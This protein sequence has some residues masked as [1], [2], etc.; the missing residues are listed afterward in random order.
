MSKFFCQTCHALGKSLKGPGMA[1]EW[2]CLQKTQGLNEPDAHSSGYAR[3]LTGLVWSERCETKAVLV[4]ALWARLEKGEG[5]MSQ[6]NKVVAL[7]GV[8]GCIFRQVLGIDNAFRKKA[9]ACTLVEKPLL[10]LLTAF[11]NVLE[12]VLFKARVELEG[13]WLQCHVAA[14]FTQLSELCPWHP[15]LTHQLQE[16]PALILVT[17]GLHSCW[18]CGVLFKI[19][20]LLGSKNK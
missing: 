19:Q 7:G 13:A 10:L 6:R 2:N 4:A 18:G 3:E 5:R 14:G 20:H 16:G 1:A 12:R 15:W 11:P 8:R 9:N 17:P